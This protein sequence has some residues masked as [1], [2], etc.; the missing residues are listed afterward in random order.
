MAGSLTP[1]DYA[2]LF[3][4]L[5]ARGEVREAVHRASA[6]QICGPREARECRARIW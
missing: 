6:G 2:D 5:M 3:D 4:A 1:A